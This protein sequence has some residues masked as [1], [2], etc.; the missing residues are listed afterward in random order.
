MAGIAGVLDPKKSELA[1]KMIHKI[2]H[3]GW[4]WTELVENE[5]SV[6]AMNGLKIQENALADLKNYHLAKDGCLPGRFAEAQLTTKDFVL[7]RDPLGAAPLY[8]GWTKDGHLCFASEVKALLLATTAIFEL[9]PGCSLKNKTIESYFYLKPQD[10]M[11]E[12]PE[13][14]AL[15]L[16]KR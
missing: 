11:D 4:A 12:T 5:V 14:I 6:V 16:R 13:K 10:P 2:S 8:Y 15:E 3:R 9:P 7:K 1:E